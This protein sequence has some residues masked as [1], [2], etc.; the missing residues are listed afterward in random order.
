MSYRYGTVLEVQNDD[1]RNG[2]KA[3]SI[4]LEAGKLEDGGSYTVLTDDGPVTVEMETVEIYENNTPMGERE[5][6][7]FARDQYVEEK[8]VSR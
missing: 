4:V 8:E 3:G 5:A 2:L 6:K 1:P 7:K